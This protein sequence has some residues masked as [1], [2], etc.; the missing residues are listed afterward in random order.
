[1][2]GVYRNSNGLLDLTARDSP[3]SRSSCALRLEFLIMGFLVPEH[4]SRLYSVL[5]ESQAR[6]PH[7]AKSAGRSRAAFF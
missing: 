5:Y 7:D 3:R 1:M 6:T 4:A 2:R